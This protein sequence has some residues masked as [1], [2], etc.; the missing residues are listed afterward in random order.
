M[1]DALRTQIASQLHEHRH[2]VEKAQAI[3]VQLRS[4]D[5]ELDRIL[6]EWGKDLAHWFFQPH[7]YFG[8]STPVEVY[9]RNP[10]E[11]KGFLQ[12]CLE[13]TFV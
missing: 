10:N 6:V 12:K 8:D 7:R 3:L 1:N 9:L 11:V 2:W 13:G 4:A 5:D